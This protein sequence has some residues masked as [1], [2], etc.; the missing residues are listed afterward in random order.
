MSAPARLDELDP[1]ADAGRLEAIQQTCVLAGVPGLALGLYEA[2][3]TDA[4]AIRRL[5]V[6]CGAR[7]RPAPFQSFID[8]P[9][10]AADD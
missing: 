4:E 8:H 10:P 1:F 6:E 9:Y 5:A 3:M 7:P 2:G